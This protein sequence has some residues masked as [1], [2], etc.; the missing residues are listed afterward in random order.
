MGIDSLSGQSKWTQ[1]SRSMDI[2]SI[3]SIFSLTPWWPIGSFHIFSQFP[4]LSP[5]LNHR[6]GMMGQFTAMVSCKFSLKPIQWFNHAK[7]PHDK[8]SVPI[9][10]EIP[11]IRVGMIPNEL[12]IRNAGWKLVKIASKKKQFL[13]M[14]EV[15]FFSYFWWF[16]TWILFFHHIGKNHPNWRTP[17]FFRGVGRKTTNQFLFLVGYS[18]LG[19]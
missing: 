10:L 17:S 7:F 6:I 11:K 19:P 4:H 8:S 16:G 2:R 18:H 12:V 3:G 5:S 14:S 13:P 9:P 15:I 1:A